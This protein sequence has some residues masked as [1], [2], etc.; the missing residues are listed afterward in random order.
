MEESKMC[1]ILH[2]NCPGH[3]KMSNVMKNKLASKKNGKYFKNLK[4]VKKQTV[5]QGNLGKS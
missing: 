4:R 1:N 2:D 5:Q 3:F